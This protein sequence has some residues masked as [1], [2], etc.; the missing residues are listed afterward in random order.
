MR[1][2]V[3]KQP[4]ARQPNKIALMKNTRKVAKVCELGKQLDDLEDLYNRTEDP[5]KKA[6]IKAKMDVTHDKIVTMSAE[7]NEECYGK[8]GKAAASGAATDGDSE[9][10]TE[11]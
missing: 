11:I 9:A 3:P 2:N 10:G 6:E 8:K 5:E 4:G 7:I 1:C